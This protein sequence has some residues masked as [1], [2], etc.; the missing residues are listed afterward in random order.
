MKLVI[1]GVKASIC[2]AYAQI[3]RERISLHTNIKFN[4][5]NQNAYS[6][7]RVLEDVIPLDV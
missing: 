2:Y 1:V 4:V 5:I 3:V 7:V 6:A